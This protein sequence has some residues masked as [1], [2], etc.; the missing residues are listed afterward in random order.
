MIIHTN[1]VKFYPTSLEILLKNGLNP[2]SLAADGNTMLAICAGLKKYW[3]AI[4][5]LV[6]YGADI[7]RR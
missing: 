2:D 4:Q 3:D 7:N 1:A 5:L 6:K